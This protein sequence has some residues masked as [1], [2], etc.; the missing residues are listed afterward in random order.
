[1][2]LQRTEETAFAVINVLELY[3]AIFRP[4]VHIL[5]NLGN[6][7]LKLL[8]LEPGSREGLLHSTE[9]L[10]LLVA[11]SHEAGLLGGS[12]TRCGGAGI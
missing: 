7:V 9:E 4:A 10:K 6:F 11:A 2:A 5:N 3:L 1:L 12:R 8:G